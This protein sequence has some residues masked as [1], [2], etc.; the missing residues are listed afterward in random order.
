[1]KYVLFILLLFLGISSYS[2]SSIF[3]AQAISIRFFND[4]SKQFEDWE[5]WKPSIVIITIAPDK[6]HIYSTYDQEYIPITEIYTI[7]RKNIYE[8]KD[9]IEFDA[10][11]I[12]GT[13][14]SIELIHLHLEEN[15]IYIRWPNLQL[16]YKFKKL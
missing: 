13:K 5:E 12:N 2:Q 4:S 1:M 8:F 3:K 16:V 9:T 7:M 11:D 15:Y 10:L 14:C 6:I